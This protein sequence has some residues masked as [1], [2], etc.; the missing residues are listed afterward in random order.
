[1][2][3]QN[4]ISK[5]GDIELETTESQKVMGIVRL[6]ILQFIDTNSDDLELESDGRMSR[7]QHKEIR[8]EEEE[9]EKDEKEQ[10]IN[11][12]C[13]QCSREFNNL[14]DFKMHEN[15]CHICEQCNNWYEKREDLEDHRE[16]RHKRYTCDQ[17][18]YDE[19]TN[20]TELDD[21]IREWHA[22][23][24]C[25]QCENS[26]RLKGNLENHI[27]KAHSKECEITP[28]FRIEK[29]NYESACDPC[30]KQFKNRNQLV[31]HW[32]DDHE[33]HIY[34]CIHLECRTK[35]ICQKSWKEHMK[36]KHGIGFNCSQCN[37]FY[38]FEDQLE[39]H[40]EDHIEREEYIEPNEFQ[41][42]ELKPIP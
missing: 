39:E 15:N 5:I 38:F 29:Q 32:E 8:L 31:E 2:G 6:I 42:V 11:N 27:K 3:L 21:H 41:C 24:N 23:Y 13:L 20:K 34:I 36:N 10:E 26:Y 22:E 33:T 14:E 12:K 25:N 19:S 35:Y 30:K 37:E 18:G 16:R 7:T 9:L 1:M 28:E 4:Y 17:C 40:L